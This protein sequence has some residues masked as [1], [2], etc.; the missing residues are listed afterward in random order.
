MLGTHAYANG[1]LNAFAG[2]INWA[3][4]PIKL[5]L[6][7]ATY[8]PS[9][10]HK[11]YSDISGTEVMNGNGYTTGGELLTSKTNVVS[12]TIQTLSA[13]SVSWTSSGPGFSSSYA[14]G[15]DSASSAL[16]FYIDLGGV[17]TVV[18]GAVFTLAFNV[19]GILQL[20]VN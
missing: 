16:I 8:V 12:G 14:I 4:D 5:A 7:T 15:Y 1:L 18:G 3:S 20:M 6:C 13:A 19:A 2:N 10:T 17:Q 9:Q 11:L